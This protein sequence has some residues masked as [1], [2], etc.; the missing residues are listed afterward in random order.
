MVLER[1]DRFLGKWLHRGY[2]LV[3]TLIGGA[4]VYAGYQIVVVDGQLP[5]LLLLLPGAAALVFGIWLIWTAGR[6]RL[7]DLEF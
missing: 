5:G 6:R 3:A 4:A 2:G 7:S 1:L